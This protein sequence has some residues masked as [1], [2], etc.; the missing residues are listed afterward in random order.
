VAKDGITYDTLQETLMQRLLSPVYLLHGA[1][2]FLR[3]EA[4]A[5]IVDAALTPEQRSFNLD[6]LS[7]NECDAREI[8]DRASSF[9][10]MAEHRVVVVRDVDKLTLKDTEVLGGYTEGPSPSS[11]LILAATKV[12]MRRKAFAAVKRN[13]MVVSCAPLYENQLPSW[14]TARAKRQGKTLTPEACRMVVAYVGSSLRELQNELEKIA[15]YVGERPEVTAD[16]VGAV[17]GM[18]KEYTI[19]ELQK[20]IGARD[21]RRSSAIVARMLEVGEGIPFIVTMLTSYLLTLLK[22]HDLRRKGV[23]SKELAGILKVPP[24]YLPEYQSAA[25]NFTR[26]EVEQSFSYLS[27]ADELTKTTSVDPH[28]IMQEFLISVIG[29]RA[30]E[31]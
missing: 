16:D 5:A 11:V 26:G 29:V 10:M 8:I 30:P 31:T 22:I 2:D 18:S 3:D 4:T 20:A 14:V 12:D 6:V 17:V 27:R 1:E 9:P 7:G 21:I 23:S 19:F 13:G 25:D 15:I 28:E 24:F